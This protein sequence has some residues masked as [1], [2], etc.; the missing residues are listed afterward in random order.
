M[1]RLA[2]WYLGLFCLLCALSATAEDVIFNTEDYPPYNFINASDELDGVSTR[3]LQRAVDGLGK[4]VTFRLV[5]WARAI[6]E[7]R[8]RENVCVYSTSRTPE[9]EQQFQWIGPLIES[10]WA[11]FSINE[12]V[13]DSVDSLDDLRNYRV[14]SFREDAVGLYVESR[15]V[16]V[17]WA[18]RDPENLLRLEAGLIDVW[19]TGAD[20]AEFVAGNASTDL[21]RLFTFAQSRL[22]LA[23]HPSVDGQWLAQLQQAIDRLKEQGVDREMREAVNTL[24]RDEP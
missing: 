9:R 21:T 16:P 10:S 12:S 23:C 20:V 14:G 4:D 15:G 17:I 13:A 11:A 3:L 6:T 22:Y 1:S 2:H 19:V 24:Q 7:A 18:S 8:L 5:P